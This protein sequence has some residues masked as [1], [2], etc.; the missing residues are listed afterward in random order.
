MKYRIGMVILGVAFKLNKLTSLFV[1]TIIDW[2]H[3]K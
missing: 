3:K 1:V 2:I